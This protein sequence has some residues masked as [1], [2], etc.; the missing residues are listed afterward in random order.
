M[1]CWGVSRPLGLK[2]W[3]LQGVAYG[4][5]LVYGESLSALATA[6]TGNPR[7]YLTTFLGLLLFVTG[8]K[9]LYL[10]LLRGLKGPSP[11]KEE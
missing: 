7:F 2:P 10:D 6:R 8:Q 11:S 4:V 1:F 9:S 5:R 3:S